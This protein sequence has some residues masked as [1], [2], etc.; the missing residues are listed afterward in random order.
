MSDPEALARELE[1]HDDYRVLRRLVPV[2]RFVDPSPSHQLRH[3]LVVD[4]ETTGVEKATDVIIELG[5]LRFTYDARTGQPVDVLAAESLLEDPGRPIPEEIVA[6]TGITDD[7]VRGQRIPDARVHELLDG[8]GIVLAHNASFDRPFI[9]RRLPAFRDVHW[10]CTQRDIDWRALGIGSH[11]LEFLT[12]R[13]LGA[14][15]DGH[16][17]V[18]DCRATL[19]LLA[20][21]TADGTIP[22]ARLL[23]SCRTPRVRVCAVQSPFETKDV[24]RARGYKWSGN[25]GAPAK[26]WCKEIA[27]SELTAEQ[28]W[29]RSAV[30]TNG[31]GQAQVDKVD[32]KRRWS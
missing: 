23:E 6:L 14:F 11:S 28:E 15:F 20:T 25:D 21:A 22:M 16:R 3:A 24:L 10:G 17:A 19:A 9:E 30:Y 4:V 12:Y 7:M 29:L 18:D 27:E 5:L 1:Q 32:L 31:R 2:V 8:V 13:H 26:T